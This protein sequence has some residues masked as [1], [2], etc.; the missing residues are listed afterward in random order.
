ML[1]SNCIDCLDRTNVAQFAFG[2]VALGRQLEALGVADAP[3][4]DPRS[5]I[6]AQLV[7]LYE[8]AGNTLARQVRPPRLPPPASLA[9]FS[10]TTYSNLHHIHHM[11]AWSTRDLA[12]A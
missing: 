11:Y 7:D 2:L 5:S 8:A 6:A 1:R 12:M 4:L 3:R 9:H 10:Y